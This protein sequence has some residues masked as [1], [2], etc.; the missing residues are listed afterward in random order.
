MKIIGVSGLARSG[1]DSFYFLSRDKLSNKGI[2]SCR[3]AF[4]DELKNECDEFLRSNLGISSFTENNSE[5][6]FIR[7]FL[8]TY[9]THLRRKADPNCWISKIDSRVK[10]K[11][12]TEK[13][14]FVTDVRFENEIDWIHSLGGKSVHVTRRGIAAPNQEELENDPILKS[15]SD[16]FIEWLDFA[17]EN[18]NEISNIVDEALQSIL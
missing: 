1:K 5:K 18:E 7:P 17:P 13:I 14:I 2:K 3:M 11:Q 15:K 8:V 9:G 4:A 12:N 10:E 6:E 16:F